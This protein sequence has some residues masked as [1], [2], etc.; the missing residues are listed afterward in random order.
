[1][2]N[3]G[4]VDDNQDSD[5]GILASALWFAA[6]GLPVLPLWG[7]VG[8]ICRCGRS[9]CNSPGKHP[10]S[11]LVRS[12]LKDAT[13][14]TN[15]IRHWWSSYPD[16]NLGIVTGKVAVIDV[17]PRN[18]GNES[19][20]QIQAGNRPLPRTWCALTGGGGFHLYYKV[21]DNLS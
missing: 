18:G 2:R 16:N 7:T 15:R 17:D 1:M 11:P 8:N 3:K 9:E 6:Q 13:K 12:G 5:K 4:I 14:D 19:F 10:F 20:Q 21:P